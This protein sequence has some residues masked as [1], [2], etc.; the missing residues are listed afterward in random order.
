MLKLLTLSFLLLSASCA[1]AE[2][3]IITIEHRLMSWRLCSEMD[4]DYDNT[5]FCFTTKE[6]KRKAILFKT[7]RPL[8]HYCKFADRKCY[9]KWG[10]AGKKLGPK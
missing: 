6:C 10:L 9:S 3:K 5:G 7:C 4:G 1:T 8:I 2:W